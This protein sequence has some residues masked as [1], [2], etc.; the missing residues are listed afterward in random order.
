M[1]LG[2]QTFSGFL[3]LHRVWTTQFGSGVNGEGAGRG[4]VTI[5]PHENHVDQSTLRISGLI[6]TCSSAI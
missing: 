4:M 1:N 3:Y 5:A 2:V 6:N